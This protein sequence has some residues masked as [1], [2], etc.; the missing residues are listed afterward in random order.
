LSYLISYFACKVNTFLLLLYANNEN[1][2]NIEIYFRKRLR[3]TIQRIFG[4]KNNHPA[5]HFQECWIS[6]SA[7]YLAIPN[8]FP[9]FA[10]KY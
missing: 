6:F 7:N 9:N 4:T 2:T 3:K 8:I 10:I 5:P 1:V